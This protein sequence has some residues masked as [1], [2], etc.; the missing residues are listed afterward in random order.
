MLP[1]FAQVPL[2][3]APVSGALPV[4]TDTHAS[5]VSVQFQHTGYAHTYTAQPMQPQPM[6]PQALRPQPGLPPSPPVTTPG[7]GGGTGTA[8]ATATAT[9]AKV[10]TVK[11]FVLG[12]YNAAKS[13]VLAPNQCAHEFAQ[14]VEA[15]RTL[16]HEL[17]NKSWAAGRM[18]LAAAVASDAVPLYTR[19]AQHL[20]VQAQVRTTAFYANF[21]PWGLDRLNATLQQL[22]MMGHVLRYAWRPRSPDGRVEAPQVRVLRTAEPLLSTVGPRSQPGAWR[23]VRDTT[24]ATPQAPA[25]TTRAGKSVARQDKEERPE[26]PVETIERLWQMLALTRGLDHAAFAQLMKQ[27]THFTSNAERVRF[28]MTLVE[29]LKGLVSCFHTGTLSMEKDAFTECL[30]SGITRIGLLNRAYHDKFSA[31]LPPGQ[32]WQSGDA[33]EGEE[34]EVTLEGDAVRVHFIWSLSHSRHF[35]G[36]F[37]HCVGSCASA[38]SACIMP[39][40]VVSLLEAHFSG[41]STLGTIALSERELYC[42]ATLNFNSGGKMPANFVRM[43]RHAA[44][45]LVELPPLP[46]FTV[47]PLPIGATPGASSG[48]S[49]GASVGGASTATTASTVTTARAP[50]A[51][52]TGRPASV[53]VFAPAVVPVVVPAVV[54]AVAPAVAPAFHPAVTDTMSEYD[55]PAEAF[56]SLFESY[57]SDDFF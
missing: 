51:G 33:Q 54:P 11:T 32:G 43:V 55:P 29:L 49:S 9:G 17:I 10:D 53:P 38:L 47:P 20:M 6:Q 12:S 41:E 24:G 28:G 1:H 35:F 36:H 23:E 4:T 5:P 42:L 50:H 34:S 26:P 22:P 8:T 30:S 39:Q 21:S 16:C 56:G 18:D 13:L 40:R 7:A 25:V 31:E 37:R 19:C 15:Y 46:V 48:A 45:R 14:R 2:S 57:S 3:T 44:Q 52:R 27:H